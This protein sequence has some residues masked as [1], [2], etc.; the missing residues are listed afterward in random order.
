MWVPRSPS[1]PSFIAKPRC[2][3]PW[4]S[5][6][7][8]RLPCSCSL[9]R[10]CWDTCKPVFIPFLYIPRAAI[11]SAQKP[12][13]L[14]E[15]ETMGGTHFLIEGRFKMLFIFS[16]AVNDP[17]VCKAGVFYSPFAS[18]VQDI[19]AAKFA[20]VWTP[21]SPLQP[22]GLTLL[23][24]EQKLF[25]EL[26]TRKCAAGAHPAALHRESCP[27]IPQVTPALRL[28]HLFL[29]S[30]NFP[31]WR[32]LLRHVEYKWSREDVL[33]QWGV[34]EETTLFG[35]LSG[36]SFIQLKLKC[37]SRSYH[38][39]LSCF[40]FPPA[41]GEKRRGNSMANCWIIPGKVL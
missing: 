23:M 8:G 24:L 35:K 39:Q 41:P 33:W 9:A 26:S 6:A 22:I 17:I 5:A 34:P 30:A 21:H 31:L 4:L 2:E 19:E 16:P 25:P 32:I 14:E 15:R 7:K 1:W 11:C 37:N 29:F 3:D 20:S 28:Q 40:P 13:Y 36:A 10:K 27:V 18:A 12:F 38:T